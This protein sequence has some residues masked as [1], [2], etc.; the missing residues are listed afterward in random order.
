MQD[1]GASVVQDFI[2]QSEFAEARFRLSRWY[3][4]KEKWH[5]SAWDAKYE[6]RTNPDRGYNSAQIKEQDHIV[7]NMTRH[8]I[9]STA[10]FVIFLAGGPG[11]GKSWVLKWLQ[12]KQCYPVHQAVLD[13]DAA[14]CQ[15]SAWA[16]NADDSPEGIATLVDATQAGAGFVCEV[17]ALRC[18]M[19]SKSFIY[20]STLRLEGWASEFIRLLQKVQPR[21]RT[22]ILFVDSPVDVCK[23]RAHQRFL[24]EKRNVPESYI[25][26]CNLASRATVASLRDS[27]DLYTHV[28]NDSL[29]TPPQATEDTPPEMLREF[30]THWE[31][32]LMTCCSGTL[33]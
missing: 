10:P 26:S 19:Q 8:A 29:H 2:Q 18:A 24:K 7:G 12:D 4:D 14:R 6:D 17:A 13:I 31:S 21:L 25:E 11:S 33:W 16:T 27:V 28:Y 15:S 32:V 5:A 23:V 3:L 20:D 9:K 1:L 22:C 30:I